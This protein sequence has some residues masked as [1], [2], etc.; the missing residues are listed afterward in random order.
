MALHQ[1]LIARF[2]FLLMIAVI[3]N[4]ALGQKKY[5]KRFGND[6]E[7]LNSFLIILE[8]QETLYSLTPEKKQ[9]K[10]LLK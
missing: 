8:N 1:N 6:H 4:I 7:M 10:R 9:E 5:F 2:C 3:M